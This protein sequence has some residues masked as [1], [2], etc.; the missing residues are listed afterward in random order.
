MMDGTDG[1]PQAAG[2]IRRIGFT[3]V[4]TEV[5][6]GE[7]LILA[8]GTCLPLSMRNGSVGV[9]IPASYPDFRRDQVPIVVKPLLGGFGM[10]WGSILRLA[11]YVVS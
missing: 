5:R 10:I 4:R 11:A 3:G 7:D 6:T 8:D 2:T 9:P 1:T